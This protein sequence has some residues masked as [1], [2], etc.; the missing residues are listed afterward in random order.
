ME[1][2]TVIEIL[3]EM[4]AETIVAEILVYLEDGSRIYGGGDLCGG[5]YGRGDIFS[6]LPYGRNTPLLAHSINFLL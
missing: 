6:Y 4:V 5:N 1:E 2:I 3:N